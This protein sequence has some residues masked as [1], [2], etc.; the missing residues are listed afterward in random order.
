MKTWQFINKGEPLGP[1]SVDEPTAGPGGQAGEI[2]SAGLCHTDVGILDDGG[3]LQQ[4]GPRPV[5]LGHE[6]AGGRRRTRAGRGRYR[7]G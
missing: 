5:T 4:L 1:A 7:C 3:W 6:V 2:K